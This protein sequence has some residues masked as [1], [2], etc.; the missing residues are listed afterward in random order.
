MASKE[1][2]GPHGF[3]ARTQPRASIAGP[4]HAA[5][6]HR[7]AEAEKPWKG[8]ASSDRSRNFPQLWRVVWRLPKSLQNRGISRSGH[9]EK[10]S[11]SGGEDAAMLASPKATKR[12]SVRESGASN[13]ADGGRPLE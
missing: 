2:A 12:R 5:V 6:V 1:G 13:R 3:R 7:Q 9:V 10:S 8:A 4:I 11:L